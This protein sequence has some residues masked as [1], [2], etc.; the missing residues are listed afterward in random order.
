MKIVTIDG[1]NFKDLEGFYD[2]VNKKLCPGFKEFGRNLA[3]FNDVLRGGFNV[4]EYEENIQLIWINSAKSKDDLGYKAVVKY[5]KQVKKK[6]HPTNIQ[7]I[8]SEIHDAKASK[9]PTLYDILV[10]IIGDN[11]HILFTAQ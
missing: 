9:G 8:K 6:A 2:E 3:A 10:G 1:N 7:Y 5:L 11:K 4:F